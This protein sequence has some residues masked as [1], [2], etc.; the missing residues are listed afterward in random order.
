MI[1]LAGMLVIM[2]MVISV[3]LFFHYVWNNVE[4]VLTEGQ[5]I[6]KKYEATQHRHYYVIA[7]HNDP[8]QYFE[9]DCTPEEWMMFQEGDIV[10]CEVS[11]NEFNTIIKSIKKN[12]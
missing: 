3:I 9:Y 1:S 2:L 4:T 12:D 10:E 6:A 11:Y 5:I 8:V 7:V